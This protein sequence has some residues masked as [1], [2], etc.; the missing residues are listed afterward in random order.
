MEKEDL[1]VPLA[2]MKELLVK[3]N[4]AVEIADSLIESVTQS[5]LGKTISSFTG[6]ASILRE[7]METALQRILTPKKSTDLLREILTSKEQGKPFSI[8]SAVST[9]W[10]SPP[11]WPRSG[12]LFFPHPFLPPV[13]PSL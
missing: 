9:V 10:A 11:T 12:T 3:K 5:L 6:I 8:S 1:E 13:G 7:S 2:N 4:V